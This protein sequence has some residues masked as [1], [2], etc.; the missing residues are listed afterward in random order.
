[1]KATTGTAIPSGVVVF[2]D[3]ST[4][5]DVVTLDS[6]GHA[7]FTTS[8]LPVGLRVIRAFYI[9]ESGFLDSQSPR[10]FELVTS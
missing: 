2:T 6:A 8:S 7:V 5:L 4:V 1:V 9:G 10:I 3:R